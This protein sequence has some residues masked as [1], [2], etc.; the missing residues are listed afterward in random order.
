MPRFCSFATIARTLFAR[1][2]FRVAEAEVVAARLQ[3]DDARVRWHRSVETREH[4]ARGV[5]GNP[6]IGDLHFIAARLQ[7]SL[8]LRGIGL[9][10]TRA[11]TRRVAGADGDD[12]GVGLGRERAGNQPTASPPNA[13]LFA[14]E[15]CIAPFPVA[16]FAGQG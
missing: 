8:Q 7:H 13:N 2:L 1:C 9:A 3:N 10:E 12:L 15:T 5:A 6:G 16:I 4:A 11:E 14:H